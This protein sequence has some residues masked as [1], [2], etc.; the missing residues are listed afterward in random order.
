MFQNC[1]IF[2]YRKYVLF[3]SRNSDK[4]S[5]EKQKYS[6]KFKKFRAD[7]KNL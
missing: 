1:Q 7:L 4:T 3:F 6:E 2:V 5:A